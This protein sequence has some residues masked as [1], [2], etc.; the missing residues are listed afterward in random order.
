MSF[1]SPL[2]LFAG[3]A[4]IAPI[5]LHLVRRE[6]TRKVPF[7]SLMFVTRMPKKSW[8]KQKLR[9]L[10]LLSLRVAALLLLAL[11]FARPFFTWKVSAPIQTLQSRSLIVLL[12]NSF[13]MRFADRFEK[14]K[15]QTLQLVRGLAGQDSVQVVV[16]SDTSQALNSPQTERGTIQSLIRDVQPSYRTTNYAQAFK[17]A[18]QLLA[19][20][21]GEL[22]EVHWISDFQ[23]TG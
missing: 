15:T 18:N 12:D 4:I 21:P 13:S 16:F 10:L 9:H 3:L 20:A 19:S 23:Q 8:R 11:A 7:S 2:F 17:L 1:L 6:E 22:R 14:A 5:L